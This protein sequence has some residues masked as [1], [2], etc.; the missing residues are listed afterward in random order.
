[1]RDSG[2]LPED[3]ITDVT[4]T[5]LVADPLGTVRSLYAEW[6]LEL[7]DEYDALLRDYV[8]DRHTARV[9]GHD[10]DA[11]D[12]GLDLAGHRARLAPY[13]ERFGVPSEV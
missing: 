6:G 7:T 9:P 8:A 5:G 2:V 1:V 10:Y 3:Q 4:Y 13:Q 11:A 12:T